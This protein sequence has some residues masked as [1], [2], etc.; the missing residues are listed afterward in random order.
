MN[1]KS[2]VLELDIENMNNLSNEQ[3]VMAR[4]NGF[5]TSDS[6]AL[7][8]VNPF[9][10]YLELLKSKTLD[11]ITDAEKEIGMKTA[12]RKGRDLEPLVLEKWSKAFSVPCHK[13]EHQYKHKDFPYLKF[14]F[15][16]VVYDVQ[17]PVEAKVMTKYGKKYYDLSKTIYTEF[18]ERSGIPPEDVTTKPWA[19]AE[20]AKH[21][22][23]PAY[24]YTQLQ[25]QMLGLESKHGYLA[26]LDETDWLLHVF[27]VDRDEVVIRQLIL[28]G[29]EAWANVLRRK[30]MK[31]QGELVWAHYE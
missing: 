21:Y 8:G 16:G 28:K 9:T 22:G 25:Q 12:V 20:K 29:N 5:G 18:A 24:Y 4:R 26:V 15:D 31:Q 14:N 23:I 19:I 7:L 1:L 6:S 27:A 17:V 3:Y 11:G 2:K 30:E 10:S 13:P